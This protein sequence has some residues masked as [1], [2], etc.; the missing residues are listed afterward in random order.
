MVARQRARTLAALTALVLATLGGCFLPI[1]DLDISL[2]YQTASKMDKVGTIGPV[3]ISEDQIVGASEYYYVPSRMLGPT[4]GLLVVADESG[5]SFAY[6]AP[7]PLNNNIREVR[8]ET[9]FFDNGDATRFGYTV[10]PIFDDSGTVDDGYFVAFA[11]GDDAELETWGFEIASVEF[12][13]VSSEPASV[14]AV[15]ADPPAETVGIAIDASSPITNAPFTILQRDS[16]A[17][18]N[19]DFYSGAVD[20]DSLPALPLVGLPTNQLPEGFFPTGGV[21]AYDETTNV[22]IY[23]NYTA[24]GFYNVYRWTGGATPDP[25]LLPV[26]QPI[27]EILTTGE[28]YHR[29][30]GSDEVYDAAGRKKYSIASGNLHFAYEN[31]DGSEPVMVYTLVYFDRLD[32]DDNMYID[33]YTIP[34]A[35]LRDLE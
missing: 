3:A 19:I 22:Y 31:T 1:F 32:W 17:P 35:E 6:L 21:A 24:G 16:G 7:D 13:S 18:T 26:R 8:K 23:S 34:T 11:S 25:E 14:L 20:D 2:A 9:R 33:I 12:S 4:H 29:G 5:M 15:P 27:H 30:A 28:L 10:G